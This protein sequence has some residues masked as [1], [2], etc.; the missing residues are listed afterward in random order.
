MKR[1]E[2]T[3]RFYPLPAAEAEPGSACAVKR[4]RHPGTGQG[5]AACRTGN[6]YA[7]ALN[8][9]MAVS[10]RGLLTLLG[11][12]LD[13]S[14]ECEAELSE[15]QRA[16]MAQIETRATEWSADHAL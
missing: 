11:V 6:I 1:N 16:F 2:V 8:D 10:R 13:D 5:A 3:C 7:G 15:A 14:R 12:F 9:I 4:G